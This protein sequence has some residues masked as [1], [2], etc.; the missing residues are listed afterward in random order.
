V[1]RKEYPGTTRLGYYT[2]GFRYKT[3]QFDGLSRDQF[4][5]AVRAEGVPIGHSLGNISRHSQNR[6][7]S[8]EGAL[9]SKTFK[10]IY[11]EK[12]IKDYRDRLSCPEVEQLVKETVGFSQNVLLGTKEDMDDI[13]D[14]VQ[15]VYENRKELIAAS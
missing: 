3:E 2:C 12:R 13:A 1:P 10:A 11:S 7:G 8:I 6:E 5:R 15:K 4:L 14:A 9:N